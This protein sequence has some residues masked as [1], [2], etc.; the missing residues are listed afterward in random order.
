VIG[1]SATVADALST[2]LVMLSVEE[3]RLL[4]EQFPEVSAVWISPG[5]QVHAAFRASRLDLVRPH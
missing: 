5:G 3:G 4:A 1:P 2:T